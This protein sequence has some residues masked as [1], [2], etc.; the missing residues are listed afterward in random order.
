VPRDRVP[1]NRSE[2]AEERGAAWR[3]TRRVIG[4]AIHG[5]R[6]PCAPRVCAND[7]WSPVRTSFRRR[8]TMGR[9]NK[10]EV[11][12]SKKNGRLL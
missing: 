8:T 5:S 3:P 12:R 7:S 9:M 1:A 2:A 10:N 6:A 11:N 4:R